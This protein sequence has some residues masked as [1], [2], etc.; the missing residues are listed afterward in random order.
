MKYAKYFKEVRTKRQARGIS[1]FDF[2]DVEGNVYCPS[3]KLTNYRMN[4]TVCEKYKFFSPLARKEF[5][6]FIETGCY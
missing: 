3:S 1:P 2:L 4:Y 6:K 5:K